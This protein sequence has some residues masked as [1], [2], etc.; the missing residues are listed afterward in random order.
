LCNADDDAALFARPPRCTID[1]G[2]LV[3]LGASLLWLCT[4]MIAACY[5]MPGI[6]AFT[7]EQD[8]EDDWR[9]EAAPYPEGRRHRMPRVIRIITT[10]NTTA[11]KTTASR[12][13]SSPPLTKSHST[14]ELMRRAEQ[15]FD[16]FLAHSKKLLQRNSNSNDKDNNDRTRTRTDAGVVITT[17]DDTDTDSDGNGGGAT[18]VYIANR[19]DR[20]EKLTD[21]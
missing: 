2:G 15:Q 5:I 8:V 1:Q 17:I 21:V 4:A 13:R 20:I 9:A 6:A 11:P 19:L 10:A 18:E 16:R 7:A 12:P 3:M 14:A